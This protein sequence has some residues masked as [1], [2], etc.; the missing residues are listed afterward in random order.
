MNSSLLFTLSIVFLVGCSKD[1]ATDWGKGVDISIDPTA[2]TLHVGESAVISASVTPADLTNKTV[3]W[4]SGNTSVATVSGGVVQGVGIGSTTITAK[5]DR[6]GK[7]AECKVTVISPVLVKSIELGATEL[8]LDPKDQ[9][10]VFS[11]TVLPADAT[12]KG[13]D[14]MSSDESIVSVADGVLT[15]K[16]L[17]SAV[18]S[19]TARDTGHASALCSVTVVNIPDAVDLGLSVKW[20]TFNV[21]AEKPVDSGGFYAW[22]EV[23]PK[24]DYS[25]ASYTFSTHVPGAFSKYSASDGKT[26]LDTSDD[27]ASVVLGSGWRMPTRAE[28]EELMDEENCIW[29]RSTDGTRPGFTVASKKEGF[30]DNSIFLPADGYWEDA[31]CIG[32]GEVGIYW[33]SSLS[34]TP[35]NAFS[36]GFPTICGSNL[37]R[38]FGLSIRPVKE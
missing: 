24:N 13:L 15:L 4:T 37:P 25:K 34:D 17:G 33:S 30:L 2:I 28:F 29:T 18:V 11:A 31:V 1:P 32:K 16:G 23:S 22:G 19:A 9:S 14:W 26:R 3:L 5:T 20:A 12:D 8:H 36:I 21:G 7:K 27:V 35:S 10:Y 6:G 38:Y